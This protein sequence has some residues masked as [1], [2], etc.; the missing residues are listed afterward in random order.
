[1]T[2]KI[3][4]DAAIRFCR[5]DLIEGQLYQFKL[6]GYS[7]SGV[8]LESDNGNDDGAFYCNGK[9]V[10][11]V[12]E[13]DQIKHMIDS[14]IHSSHMMY[15]H[16]D[17]ALLREV[18]LII[19]NAVE[20]ACSRGSDEAVDGLID[21]HEAICKRLS[22]TQGEQHD[23]L[24]TPYPHLSAPTLPTV[25]SLEPAAKHTVI[26]LATGIRIRSEGNIKQP[27]DVKRS[28]K[29]IGR[30]IYGCIQISD[31]ER[32]ARLH[33]VYSALKEVSDGHH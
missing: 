19:Q 22:Q 11:K 1:M 14:A 30:R 7:C 3:L 10:C 32:A 8:Y 15:R 6:N 20:T 24:Q 9:A 31:F 26:D 17:E 21:A 4:Q 16:L 18:M 33:K 25:V 28:I 12:S 29:S 13:T 5:P 27:F 23:S 2:N